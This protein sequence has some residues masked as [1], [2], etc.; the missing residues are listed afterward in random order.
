MIIANSNY[1]WGLILIPL[2]VVLL[3]FS[4]RRRKKMM[5]KFSVLPIFNIDINKIFLIKN[6]RI[7]SVILTLISISLI[8]FSLAQP[9]WGILQTPISVN[10]YDVVFVLDLSKSMNAQDIKPSRLDRARHEI[11][12][13]IKNTKNIRVGLVVFAGSNFIASPL[14]YDI[15]TFIVLLNSLKTTSM[16]VPG[17]RIIDAIDTAKNIFIDNSDSTRSLMLITDGEVHTEIEKN[18]AE[19]FVDENIRIYSVALGTDDGDYIPDFD[20]K[21]R[22]LGYKKDSKGDLILSKRNDTLIKNLSEET[23]GQ[24]YI[25]DN[26]DIDFDSIFKNIKEHSNMNTYQSGGRKYQQR[27]QIFMFIGIVFLIA[28]IL[29]SILISYKINNISKEDITNNIKN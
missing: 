7:I 29:L 8:V 19:I 16:T 1:L 6:Y 5:M 26:G 17:T 14:T 12:N 24:F 27:Y 10:T 15:E 21:G 25:S 28:E 11:I 20:E 4:F 23:L 3:I 18:I 22:S 2:L 9:K 13:F